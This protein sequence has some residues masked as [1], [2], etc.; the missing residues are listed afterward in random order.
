MLS[1]EENSASSTDGS[2]SPLDLSSVDNYDRVYR[3]P[4]STVVLQSNDGV[5]FR[6]SIWSLI[7]HE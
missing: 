2:T 6:G 7:A 5:L 3:D 1:P 4:M